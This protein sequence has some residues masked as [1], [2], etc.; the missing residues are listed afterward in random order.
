[1]SYETFYERMRRPVEGPS[2]EGGSE[3]RL[4]VLATRL[5]LLGKMAVLMDTTVCSVQEQMYSK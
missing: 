3:A 2:W 5:C 4:R 1:M